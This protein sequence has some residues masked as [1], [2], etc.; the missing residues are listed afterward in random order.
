[1]QVGSL[2]STSSCA[3]VN[4]TS[5]K[6][7][8][9]VTTGTNN[10]KGADYG[11]Y[12]SGVDTYSFSSPSKSGP[13]TSSGGT[14]IHVNGSSSSPQSS[15]KAS[16][17]GAGIHTNNSSPSPS[18]NSFGSLTSGS[19][20]NSMQYSNVTPPTK[21][22]DGPSKGSGTQGAN[23]G[24]SQIGTYFNSSSSATKETNGPSK[25]SGTQGANNGNSQI[26]TY[27][28]SSSSATK[29]TD[30]SSGVG[31][32][33]TSPVNALGSAAPSANSE[34]SDVDRKLVNELEDEIGDDTELNNAIANLANGGEEGN[35][36]TSKGFIADSIQEML[37]DKDCSINDITV[38]GGADYLSD[39][40]KA[41]DGY[42]ISDFNIDKGNISQEFID[43]VSSAY[44]NATPEERDKNTLLGQLY[45]QTREYILSQA[46]NPDIYDAYASQMGNID[47]GFD[48]D[49]NMTLSELIGNLDRFNQIM[50]I[51]PHFYDKYVTPI[52]T[53]DGKIVYTITD[54]QRAQM[55]SD[56]NA[57]LG[58]DR[59]IVEDSD[60]TMT[61]PDALTWKDDDAFFDKFGKSAATIGFV[62]DGG[63]SEYNQLNKQYQDC[64]N[65]C[66]QFNEQGYVIYNGK[67]YDKNNAQAFI[68]AMN[69]KVDDIQKQKDE[70]ERTESYNAAVAATAGEIGWEA[71]KFGLGVV[72]GGAVQVTLIA[73]DAA[74]T[75]HDTIADGGSWD[76]ALV[77][78]VTNA[79]GNVLGNAV[80]DWLFPG[81]NDAATE[82][83]ERA[84]ER[85]TSEASERIAT[86]VAENIAEATA[87]R[88][89]QET[90]ENISKEATESVIKKFLTEK[91]KY[92]L[93]NEVQSINE[94]FFNG[95]YEEIKAE[96]TSESSSEA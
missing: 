51:D 81:A 79:A 90:G 92:D 37:D 62:S 22:T 48:K 84:T 77:S 40:S 28:N 58:D 30:G 53:K 78:S 60:Y 27:F 36:S 14:N 87:R 31:N 18:S 47:S 19:R 96:L 24:N 57:L 3:P 45:A 5:P 41:L 43:I 56:E 44:Q 85:L 83:T 15:S 91:F 42:D 54:A 4:R 50:Q 69:A 59:N 25:G 32:K 49:Q 82:I 29:E 70:I 64:Q 8:P 89:A 11:K 17:G 74:I 61:N 80:G 67:R 34:L 72:G 26:G 13:A 75:A 68:N 71:A 38:A 73:A 12:G 1:M 46:T 16:S 66:N 76:E 6:A 95:A 39:L 23:N 52:K 86:E 93:G 20:N 10:S 2:P 63:W 21:G 7:P 65:L 35:Y 88:I 33:G 55:I 9:K 94:D